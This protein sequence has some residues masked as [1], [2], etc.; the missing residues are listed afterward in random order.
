M[1]LSKNT[2]TRE[3][4]II[5]YTRRSLKRPCTT[6]TRGRGCDLMRK[7]CAAAFNAV[8]ILS[9]S[10]RIVCRAFPVIRLYYARLLPVVAVRGVYPVRCSFVPLRYIIA[11]MSLYGRCGIA[12]YKTDS[13][14]RQKRGVPVMP[15]K[16]TQKEI[17]TDRVIS[18]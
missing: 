8:L 16:D 15:N 14:A 10:C 12:S 18:L 9:V 4:G 3:S 2:R 13:I 1:R 11:S 17:I 7:K 5:R 6:L